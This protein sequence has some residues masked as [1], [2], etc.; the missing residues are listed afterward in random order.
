MLKELLSVYSTY[1]Y[2]M[3]LEDY[4]RQ[5]NLTRLESLLTL[6]LEEE[7]EKYNLL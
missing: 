6:S 2:E 1:L 4:E 5:Y 3:E 7:E